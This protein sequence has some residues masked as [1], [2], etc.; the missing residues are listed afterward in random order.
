LP[1]DFFGAAL[2]GAFLEVGFPEL[3]LGVLFFDFS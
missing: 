3:F 2:A 1:E